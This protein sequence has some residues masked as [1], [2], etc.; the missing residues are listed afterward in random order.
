MN[1]PGSMGPEGTSGA[2]GTSG[3]DTSHVTPHP[4]TSLALPELWNPQTTTGL[5]RLSD[6]IQRQAAMIGYVNAFYMMAATAAAAVP[7]ACLLRS[8]A[9]ER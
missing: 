9:R 8:V 7:L 4:P 3:S 5:M 6:E 1:A 2:P